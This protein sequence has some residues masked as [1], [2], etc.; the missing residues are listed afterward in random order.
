MFALFTWGGKKILSNQSAKRRWL[1]RLILLVT[2][3]RWI[4]CRFNNKSSLIALK[5]GETLLI[6]V[7]KNG[8]SS[9]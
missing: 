9:Q 8:A 3:L 5:R 6:N 2:L 4:D 7:Q 1:R